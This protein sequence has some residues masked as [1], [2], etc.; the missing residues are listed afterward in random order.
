MAFPD[1]L[2]T[3]TD[4][5]IGRTKVNTGTYSNTST[6]ADAGEYNR[7]LD[8]VVGIA[9]SLGRP[10]GADASSAWQAILGGLGGTQTRTTTGAVSDATGFLAITLSTLPITATVSALTSGSRSL[11][12]YVT[13]TAAAPEVGDPVVA[14]ISLTGGT[15]FGGGGGNLTFEE[16]GLYWFHGFGGDP[17]S[18][19]FSRTRLDDIQSETTFQSWV[20]S[21]SAGKGFS[22][23][24]LNATGPMPDGKV[25]VVDLTSANITATLPNPPDGYSPWPR[26]LIIIQ[27]A[28]SLTLNPG[29]SSRINGGALDADYVVPTTTSGIRRV[30]LTQSGTPGGDDTWYVTSEAKLDEVTATTDALDTRL[31]A[32]EANEWVTLVRI[33][34]AVKSAAQN[35][36]SLRQI[37]TST[38]AAIGT[39]APGSSVLAAA[40]DHVHAHGSQTDGTHHA[41]ATTSVAGFMSA[42]DKTKTDRYSYGAGS[43]EGVVTA[44]VGCTYQDTTNGWIW[45]K[46]SGT[47]NTGWRE[48]SPSESGTYT[49]TYTAITNLDAVSA[50]GTLRYMRVGDTVFVGGAVNID[51][52]ASGSVTFDASLPIASAFTSTYN[53]SGQVN[54]QHLSGQIYGEATNDVARCVLASNTATAA[55]DVRVS[56][57]YVVL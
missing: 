5:S 57:S 3:R 55:Y 48:I 29:A 17:T 36:E 14:T 47:G 4:E 16:D 21:F 54:T 39:A 1:D 52:T 41:A 23:G 46:L 49:P 50:V 12:V 53:A 11:L 2:P 25:I 26:E 10:T 7:L 18:T 31:D 9:A 15:I 40:G 38:P 56:F 34:A 22:G 35:V 32:I 30:W 28:Y 43:P 8:N 20:Q 27:G 6:Q 37:Y 51:P 33:A 19:W 24:L 13:G 42:A 45:Q 44:T